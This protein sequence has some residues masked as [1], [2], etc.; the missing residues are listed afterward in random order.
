MISENKATFVVFATVFAVVLVLFGCSRTVAGS[1]PTAAQI[2]T[3]QEIFGYKTKLYAITETALS[4]IEQS[5]PAVKQVFITDERDYLFFAEPKGFNGVIKIAV[6][7]YRETDTSAA[8]KILSHI[9]TKEYV[10]DFDADWFTYRFFGKSVFDALISVKMD[11]EN[12]N[13]IVAITGSTIT[14]NA[15]IEGVN[16]VFGAYRLHTGN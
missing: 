14:T 8:I 4:S 16:Q 3:A 11:A 9:E 6:G 15:V 5:F 7:I 2:A 12:P 1:A 13:E 10:R